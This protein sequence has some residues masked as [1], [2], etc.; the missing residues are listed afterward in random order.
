[1]LDREGAVPLYH[2]IYLALRDEILCGQRPFGSVMPTEQQLSAQ[3]KV[4][5]ITA[6]RVLGD[7]AEQ[8]YVERR[9]RLG[10]RVIFTSPAK[11]IEANIDQAV[12]SLMALGEGT[13]VNVISVEHR[14]ATDII[15][16][17]LKIEEGADVIRA[18]RVRCLEGT[19][20]GY[21]VSYVRGGLAAVISEGTLSNA[22]L[23]KLLDEAGFHADRAEQTIGAM[24]A[25]PSLVDALDVEPLS[26]I[27]RITRTVYDKNNVPFLRTYAHYRADRFNIRLDLQNPSPA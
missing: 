18:V 23:L 22:P 15:A 26:A 10:T 25:D 4:S 9:R 11:P 16:N 7:L 2:Q 3:Y 1:M 21:I 24:L 6:R 20:I 5:R 12:D 19:P 27:L 17:A 8:H 14:A 13:S